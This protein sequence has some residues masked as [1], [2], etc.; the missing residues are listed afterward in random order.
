MPGGT[1]PRPPRA[2]GTDSV[3]ESDLAD[4]LQRRSEGLVALFPLGRADLA[5][6]VADV[7]SSLDLADELGGVAADALG[8]DLGELDDAV[9]VDQEG[10]AVGEALVLAE[11]LEVAADLEG[12]GRRS[13]RT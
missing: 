8:G 5:R 9:R 2:T 7:L 3:G 13:W 6:V 10:A 11:D 4:E 1:G 12:G